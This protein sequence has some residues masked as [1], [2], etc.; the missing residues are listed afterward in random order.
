MRALRMGAPVGKDGQFFCDRREVC[1]D[2]H[3]KI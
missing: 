1:G 3:L 2:G